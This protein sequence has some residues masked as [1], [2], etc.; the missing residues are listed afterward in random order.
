MGFAHSVLAW[1][2]AEL[3]MACFVFLLDSVYVSVC[4]CTLVSVSLIPE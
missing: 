3:C 2:L 1:E 4:V